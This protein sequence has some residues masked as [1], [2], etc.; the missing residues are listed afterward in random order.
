[1]EKL[2][3]IPEFCGQA[4]ISRSLLYS[5]WRRGEGP[6]VTRL[7]RR[8]LISESAGNAWLKRQEVS[9]V[10]EIAENTRPRTDQAVISNE[11]P[12]GPG[13]SAA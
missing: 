10:S 2:F 8:R 5:M 7:G 6:V 13:A 11:D 12:D 1:M 9:P 3:W 4:K